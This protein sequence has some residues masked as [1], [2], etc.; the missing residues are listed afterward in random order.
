MTFQWYS[1]KDVEKSTI[2]SKIKK[3]SSNEGGLKQSKT[4]ED[5]V[6][7]A[8]VKELKLHKLGAIRGLSLW[9]G[10]LKQ[11]PS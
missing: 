11:R 8:P 10:H 1:P 6:E 2:C 4:F 9:H 3:S 5:A 7:I